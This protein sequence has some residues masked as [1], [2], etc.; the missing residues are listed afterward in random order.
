MSGW[1]FVH[2]LALGLWLGCVTIEAI[3]ELHAH[4]DAVLRAGIAR[5]H[6]WIDMLAEMPAFTMVAISG[7][8]MLD[9]ARMQGA[10][11]VMVVAGSIAIAVNLWCVLPVIRRR[12]AA[13]RD[14]AT[15]RDAQT[16]LVFLAFAM[17][18]PFGLAAL[19][20]GLLQSGMI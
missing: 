6:F 8:A 2:V 18:L 12:A 13:N 1:L 17:G 14:D 20:G 11:A 5:I 9:P 10:Y 4:R 7:I 16:R 3:L 19:F 15:T